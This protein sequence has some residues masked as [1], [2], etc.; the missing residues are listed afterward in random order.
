M[1]AG[2]SNVRNANNHSDAIHHRSLLSACLAVCLT[3]AYAGPALAQSQPTDGGGFQRFHSYLG[4]EPFEIFDTDAYGLGLFF[5]DLVLPGNHGHDLRI[6][7]GGDGTWAIGGLVMSVAYEPGIFPDGPNAENAWPYLNGGPTL[8]TAEGGA[9]KGFYMR[10][11]Q[12]SDDE[13]QRWFKTVDGLKYDQLTH[14][15]YMPDGTV[16]HYNWG[17][18]RR[19]LTSCEDAFGTFLEVLYNPANWQLETITQR[20][21]PGE[22]DKRVIHFEYE[23]GQ[24]KMIYQPTP[25]EPVREWTVHVTVDASDSSN[26]KYTYDV[27]LPTGPG[28]T[29]FYDRDGLRDVT[30]PGGGHIHYDYQDWS[31]PEPSP[32]FH[33][34]KPNA[35]T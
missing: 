21:G 10:W 6:I 19:L 18:A 2:N 5:T 25:E 22:N 32:H 16:C 26:Y 4:F 1:T 7:R 9:R 28:W 30:T 27:T 11:P 35:W 24:S 15:V 20:L 8:V 23:T 13:T 14:M 12:G 34:V 31:Q 17:I 3:L 33:A 29:M